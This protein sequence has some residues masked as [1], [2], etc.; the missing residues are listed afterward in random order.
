MGSIGRFEE[1]G[2]SGRLFDEAVFTMQPN[3]PSLHLCIFRN[4]FLNQLNQFYS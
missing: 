1:A 2:T 4:S 3:T